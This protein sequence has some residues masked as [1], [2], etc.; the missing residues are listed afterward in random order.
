M[1]RFIKGLKQA[2]WLREVDWQGLEG[3]TLDP[4]FHP[5]HDVNPEV[6]K[7]VKISKLDRALV[8][9]TSRDCPKY[10]EFFPDF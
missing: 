10:G 3:R 5:E 6:A 2:P 1:R 8:P 4:P 9:P 7:K